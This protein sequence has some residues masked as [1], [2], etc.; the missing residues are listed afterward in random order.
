MDTTIKIDSKT[1]DQL[2]ALAE[3]RGTT[4]RALIED[5][6]ASSLTPHQLRDRAERTRAF[7]ESEFGH[8]LSDE[9]NS[10]LRARM[11]EAHA[12]HRDSLR[13]AGV[14]DAA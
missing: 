5:F 7:L 8:R 6:A 11:S 10:T 12:A 9:D 3:A 13:S 2:A 14:S 4:M 1:R